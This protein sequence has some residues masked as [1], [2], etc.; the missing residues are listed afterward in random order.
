MVEWS[1][2]YLVGIP[3]IDFEHKIFFDLII[4]FETA[5]KDNSSKEIIENILEE[6]ILYAKFHFRSEE[7]MMAR[8]GYPVFTAHRDIHYH[9]IDLLNNKLT[10]LS[11]GTIRP[12]EVL[13]FLV[14]W[15]IKHT[16]MEDTKIAAFKNTLPQAE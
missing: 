7:N 10:S 8:I 2:K 14:D 9:L 12:T 13:E 6:I 11:V 15:F 1:D 3:R 5:I 16:T 4:D